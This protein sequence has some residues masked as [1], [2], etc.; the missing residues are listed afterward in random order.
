ML[1]VVYSN[2]M[3][4]L[5]AQLAELQQTQPL[6]PLESETVIVQSNELARWLSLFLANQHGIVS[7]IEF[8]YPSAYIWALFR[9]VLPNI[10]KQSSFSTDAMAWRIF[11]LLPTCRE[12]EGFES[13]DHYLGPQNDVL[14]RY[15]LAHRIADTFDQ[16]LMYRP[17]WIHEWEQGEKPH[18][19]ARL[20]QLLTKGEQGVMHRANLLDQLKSHLN[21]LNQRPAELPPRI[22]I[23]G[24]SALPPVYMDLFDLMAK[25]C[26]ITLYFLSPSDQYWGDI[27]DKK[28][29][30][31]RLIE[32]DNQDDYSINGHPLLAS[33][34]KQGQDF[35]EQLQGYS[36]EQ[37]SLF[38]AP[39]DDSLL[40]KLQQDIY[41]LNEPDERHEKQII[42]VDDDSIMVHS[43]HSAMREIEVL[44]DQ[45]LALFERHPD[46]SPTDIVVM[47]PDIAIYTP[48]IDAVFSSQPKS[49]RI[50]Y[51]IADA[52]VQKQTPILNAFIS[53]LDLPQS[54]FDVESIVSLLECTAIQKQFSFDEPAL[55][56][57]HR[58]LRDTQTRWG[59]SAKDKATLGLPEIEANTWRAGLDRLL[60][61]YAMP[62]SN[63]GDDWGLFAGKL[64]FDGISGERADIMAQLCAF[65]DKLDRTRSQLK[66]TLSSRKWQKYV[67]TLLDTF[68][69]ANNDS[70]DNELLSIRK[71][72]DSLVET[73]TLAEFDDG[74]TIDLV[75]DWLEGHLD[76]NQSQT[77][78]MG[79]G[80]TFCGMV[81]MRSIPFQVVC[82]I[83][84]NDNSYP[85]RQPVIG[86][87]LL[88]STPRRK[89]D[90]SRRDDD[91][92]LFLEAL[93]SA[94]SHLYISYVGASIFDNTPIPPSVLISDLRD[95]LCLGFES[96]EDE[97]LWDRLLTKHPLQ[98]FS[99][100]YFNTSSDKLFSYVSTHCPPETKSGLESH[101]F[102]NALPELDDTWKKVH[103]SQLNS[104]F[105]HPARYCLQQ[106]LHLRLEG[107]DAPLESREPF[108]LGGLEGWSLRQQL[109][110]YRLQDKDVM[111]AK[112]RIQA[113]GVL[114]QGH[115]G[116]HIFD[117]QSEKVEQFANTLSP[118]LPEQFL[119]P[120]TFEL[121]INNFTLTGHLDNLS[122]SGIFTYRMG[123]TKGGHL[124]SVWIQHLILNCIKPEGVQCE[125]RLFTED[126]D[127]QFQAVADAEN[128]LSDLLTLYWQGLHQP[129]PLFANTSFAFARV[130]LKEG[131]ANPETAMNAAWQGGQ[132]SSAE[133]DDLY[134]QQLY[135]DNSPLDDE[136]KALAMA[137]YE[138]ILAHLAGGEL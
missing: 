49:M 53:L 96:T 107:D 30:L 2:D 8:P 3:V 86:F 122:S 43:C 45:L 133:K 12:Q 78:F 115:I 80:V 24:L 95:V 121:D 16:Y 102:D 63:E 123:K 124:I 29:Q 132:Y 113:T 34:G 129:L 91:R 98:A 38:L 33:L 46:L 73:T 88:A 82:L 36:H 58:W 138:P 87:D 15:H 99:Q 71:T 1:N 26:E 97:E 65:I 100:R 127:Y 89:G 11:S 136:F 60:M 27:V 105:R 137:I 109:L 72:I 67:L 70:D 64:G 39:Q 7:H 66:A 44:H 37:Q 110:E 47:T 4:Q 14:K 10:P 131:R 9:K 20:W 55:E 114:P 117:E 112:Q 31:N 61:G 18:W 126:A 68:F 135:A 119:T 59:Y 118:L 101:W 83:G 41:S 134:Y 103:L 22:A 125:T 6:P 54:R 92:Y 35:F 74:M 81:P 128:I 28:T 120:Q 23:F 94:K 76:F 106:R 62:L 79:Q 51:G 5:A 85:R 32:S 77:R 116:E 84:M 93:L 69:L 111:A 56:L 90:R 57:I 104:F 50:A 25:H 19:Q 40:G 52:G 130:S 75:K 42:A 108:E 21:K 17:D 13:I 48:W